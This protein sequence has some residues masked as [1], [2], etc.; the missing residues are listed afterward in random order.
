MIEFIKK[1]AWC[2]W[3]GAGTLIISGYGITDWEWYAFIVPLV[4]LI[5]L[6]KIDIE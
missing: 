4:I 5:A 2:F 3:L 1:Y 6:E